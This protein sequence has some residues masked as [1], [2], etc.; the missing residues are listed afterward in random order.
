MNCL[1]FAKLFQWK[2]NFNVCAE[3][4]GQI[5]WQIV[6]QAWS[7]PTLRVRLIPH[8][9][10]SERRKTFEN[11]G[12]Y[13]LIIPSYN[14]K[15]IIAR[16]EFLANFPKNFSFFSSWRYCSLVLVS[17][18]IQIAGAFAQSKHQTIDWIV[19]VS[20]VNLAL[21]SRSA[22]RPIITVP[23]LRFYNSVKYQI[24]Q[25]TTKSMKSWRFWLVLS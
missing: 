20:N 4:Y 11:L 8:W 12:I 7:C 22:S 13:C 16:V 3:I 6:T 5:R 21:R 19:L 2:T 24:Q 17:R 23:Y 25:S 10:P 18:S 15:S 14:N 9:G 1:T